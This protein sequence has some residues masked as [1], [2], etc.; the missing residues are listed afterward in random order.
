MYKVVVGCHPDFGFKPNRR[1]TFLMALAFLA[2]ACRMFLVSIWLKPRC[3]TP[4][5]DL[6]VV[7]I[8]ADPVHDLQVAAIEVSRLALQI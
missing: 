5:H 6:K 8:Y 7:S 3:R 1:K 4:V 2:E